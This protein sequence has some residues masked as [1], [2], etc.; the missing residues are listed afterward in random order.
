MHIISV[1]YVNNIHF[2][3]RQSL[4]HSRLSLNVS[5][6]IDL[7]LILLGDKSL[8]YDENEKNFHTEVWKI[9]YNYFNIF[10]SFSYV[11]KK[12]NVIQILCAV[13]HHLKIAF[14]SYFTK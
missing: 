4:M 3:L 1:W 14:Y 8:G 12:K 7:Y 11:N 6:I 13:S 5:N 2:E 10:A 9:Y